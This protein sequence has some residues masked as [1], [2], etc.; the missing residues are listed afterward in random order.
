MYVLGANAKNLA[1]SRDGSERFLRSPVDDNDPAKVAVTVALACSDEPLLEL[2]PTNLEAHTQLISMVLAVQ[3]WQ[4]LF[5]KRWRQG[6]HG[7][8][9]GHG[10]GHVRRR[11]RAREPGPGGGTRIVRAQ[12][13]SRRRR[14]G[15][16]GGAR[17]LRWRFAVRDAQ[18]GELRQA[19]CGNERRKRRMRLGLG[20]GRLRWLRLNG[21]GAGAPVELLE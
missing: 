5:R 2:R 18:V 21:R 16:R 10:L 9:R 11:R 7:I 6:R 4:Q 12:Q 3:Q 20:L 1:P 17:R 14:G 8:L 15:E 13:G 19:L